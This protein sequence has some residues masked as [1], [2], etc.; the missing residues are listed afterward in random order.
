MGRNRE[1]LLALDRAIERE[2]EAAESFAARA[3][4]HALMGND[5][6]ASVDRARARYLARS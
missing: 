6:L 2:P 1:A 3:E 5:Q 4:V